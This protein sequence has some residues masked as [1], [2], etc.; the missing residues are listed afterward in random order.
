MTLLLQRMEQG[1]PGALD[2]LLPVVYDELRVI[3]RRF[4]RVQRSNHTLQPTALVHEAYIKVL[5]DRAARPKGWNDRAHF[6]SVAAIAMR[7]ILVNHARD[8]AALRRG[9][10]DAHQVT[11]TGIADF[12]DSDALDVLTV[13]DALEALHRLD[14]RQARIAELRFFGSL[15]LDETA[16]VI[17]ISRRTVALDWKM[18]KRWLARRLD[19]EG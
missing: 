9:G 5:G 2:E 19:P 10:P 17:G 15:T 3:A 13:H 12:D 1:D 16:E 4:F 6:L 11:L 7:Q 18:A 8:K 14:P